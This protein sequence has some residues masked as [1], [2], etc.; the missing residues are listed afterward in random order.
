ML[1]E[2]RVA[3]GK[4]AKM[5][6]NEV[7]IDIVDRKRRLPMAMSVLQTRQFY[8]LYRERRNREILP[9]LHEDSGS[10]FNTSRTRRS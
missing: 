7:T 2:H 4:R 10:L 3:T 5:R 6:R 1:P 8:L 9:D